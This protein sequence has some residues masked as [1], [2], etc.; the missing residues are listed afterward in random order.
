MTLSKEMKP[1]F[2]LLMKTLPNRVMLR[3]QC[4]I[5]GVIIVDD[6]SELCITEVLY[7]FRYVCGENKV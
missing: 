2:S 6:D 4:S 1:L 5:M 7:M 3:Q